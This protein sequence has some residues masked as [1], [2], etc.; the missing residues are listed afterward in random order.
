MDGPWIR[1]CSLTLTTVFLQEVAALNLR[2]E[3]LGKCVQVQDVEGNGKLT[4]DECKPGS[5]FQEWQW[6]PMTRSLRNPNTGKCLRA[7]KIQDQG[8]VGLLECRAE[9]NETQVWSCS[10]KGHLTLYGKGF[11]LSVRHDSSDIFLS[12]ERGKST[13]WKTLNER[14]VCEEPQKKPEKMEPKII[15]KIRLWQPQVNLELDAPKPTE[16]LHFTTAFSHSN[17]STDLGEP[18]IFVY[19]MEWKVTMLVLSSLALI[20]GMVILF[21]NIY[22]NSRRKTVVVLKSYTSNNEASQPGSPVS[23]EKAPLTKHP[24]KPPRSPSIQRGEILIEWKDGTVT[25]LFD[26]YQTS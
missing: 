14:M 21:L 10:K 2:N 7:H 16:P 3:L 15:A 25:P 13:K 17:S 22:Q 12:T 1:I 4:L 18:G 20:T 23:S 11:H 5:A 24:M 8:T 6:N 26:T 9:D 19:G